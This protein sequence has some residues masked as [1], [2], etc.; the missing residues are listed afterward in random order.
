M[1][2][3]LGC[4]SGEA[5]EVE[6]GFDI[7]DGPGERGLREESIENFEVHSYYK[8]LLFRVKLNN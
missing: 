2:T 6:P 3:E 5:N 1:G 7:G 4:I 8:L